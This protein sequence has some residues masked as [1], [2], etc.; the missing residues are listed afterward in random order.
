MALPAMIPET[1][2]ISDLRTRL[3]EIEEIAKETGEPV[4][5]VRNGKPT[6]LV[7]D[8]EAYNQN[9][10]RERHI[11]KLREAE[12]EA[13]YRSEALALDESRF[14]IREIALE[15]ADSSAEERQA[16]KVALAAQ[17][18]SIFEDLLADMNVDQPTSAPVSAPAL[19]R[20]QVAL[21][22]AARKGWL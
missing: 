1:R 5:L 20:E 18:P 7:M 13:K 15:D 8:C 6:L 12:I 9:V 11:R 16:R 22:R 2:P 19:E 21:G 17:G 4:V 10:Q 14:R 3:P